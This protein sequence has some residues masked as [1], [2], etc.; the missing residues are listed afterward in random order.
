MSG[1]ERH[2]HSASE[3]AV[4][5]DLTAPQDT[6]RACQPDVPTAADPAWTSD[7]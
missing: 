6:P 5:T 3:A 4:S 7:R 2:Q 1:A